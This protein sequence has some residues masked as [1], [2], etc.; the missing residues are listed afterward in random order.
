MSGRYFLKTYGCQ[1]NEYDSA[2]MAD[3]LQA[4][5]GYV[6]TDDPALAAQP[7]AGRT[8]PAAPAAR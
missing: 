8:R 1:M 2:R 4:A 3:V 6:A 5:E 7:D